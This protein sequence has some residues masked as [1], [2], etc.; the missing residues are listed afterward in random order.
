M[1]EYT[2][3]IYIKGT[4]FALATNH[5]VYI[6][7]SLDSLEYVMNKLYGIQIFTELDK[8]KL[9]KGFELMYK[10]YGFENH[11]EIIRDRFPEEFI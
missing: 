3:E 2:F 7:T 1:L 4:R 11:K 6:G 5:F 8:R 9:L 10:G